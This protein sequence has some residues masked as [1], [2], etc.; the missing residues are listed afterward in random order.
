MSA[1]QT[2]AKLDKL[3]ARIKKSQDGLSKLRDERKSLKTKLATE[4]QNEKG[5]PKKGG[6]KAGG[7]T[8]AAS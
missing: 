1:K 3:N 2:K 6:K 4:R 8:S 5:K 7:P